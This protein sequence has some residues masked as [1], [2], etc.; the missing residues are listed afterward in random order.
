M[1]K[2][3]SGKD[4]K[5]TQDSKKPGAPEFAQML[6][7]IGDRPLGIQAAQLIA[8]ARWLQ[9]RTGARQIRVESTGP[10]SQVTALTAA[11][12][13]P[14]L[15]STVQIR[16]GM[17]TLAKLLNAPVAYEAAPDLFCLDLYK[18][19]DIDRLAAMAQIK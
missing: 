13:E 1:T 10:R 17:P 16:D 19:F 11:A 2:K 5:I 4:S 9:E 8:I 18:E 15:F 6:S 12:L 3:I 7:S 14:G